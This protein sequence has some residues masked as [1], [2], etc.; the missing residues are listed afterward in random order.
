VRSF[1]VKKV[2]PGVPVATFRIASIVLWH[3]VIADTNSL[4]VN[5][6]L[7]I[8][9]ELFASR[10]EY[11]S[12]FSNGWLFLNF[13]FP[14]N[15]SSECSTALRCA[16]GSGL[17]GEEEVPAAGAEVAGHRGQAGLGVAETLQGLGRGQPVVEVGAQ[18]FVAA[19]GCLGR[20]GE[21][22]AAGT[23]R[24]RTPGWFSCLFD[25]PIEVE[26]AA[27]VNAARR[28]PQYLNYIAVITGYSAG[29]VSPA[30][31]GSGDHS[32]RKILATRS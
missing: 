22:L 3:L 4:K 8:T 16:F 21:V 6:F 14:S 25:K 13:C 23:S 1:G 11:G 26:R 12:T 24:R 28:M 20:G 32:M 15:F 18:R 27:G 31:P 10:K 9:I 17:G 7:P 29:C 5:T 19:L 2:R 30:N